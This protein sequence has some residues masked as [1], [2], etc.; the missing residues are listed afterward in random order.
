MTW[1]DFLITKMETE[2]EP[3]WRVVAYWMVIISFFSLPLLIFLIH[4][5]IKLSLIKTPVVQGEFSYISEF[6]R[7]LAAMLATMLGL[8]SWDKRLIM[9]NGNGQNTKQKTGEP[10]D[11][12]KTRQVEVHSK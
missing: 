6:H 9:K 4:V 8:N 5:T 10:S 3:L 7:I 1:K 11:A 12:I 2:A